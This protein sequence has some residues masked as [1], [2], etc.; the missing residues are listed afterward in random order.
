[1]TVRLSHFS[2]VLKVGTLGLLAMLLFL[3]GR[4]TNQASAVAYV[5]LFGIMLLQV[6]EVLY[7]VPSEE[8]E[9]RWWRLVALRVSILL[10]LGLAS[11]LVAVTGGSGSIYELV[12]LLPIVSA[13]M[14]LPGREV[15]V[16]VGG[17]VV[18]MVGFIVTGE[19]LTAS[20][21]RVKEFQDAVAATVYFTIA[22]ILAYLFA[23]AER[24]QRVHYQSL[25][26][27]LADTN[28][29][30][31]R[32]QTELTDRLHQ[33]AQMEERIQQ[34][35]QMAV[36]GEVAA[37][38]A[39]EVRNP[40]G[41]IKGATEMLAARTSEPA[42]QR[43]VAVL[44]E[45]VDRLNRAVESILRL[46]TPLRIQPSRVHLQDLL[47][48]VTQAATGWSSPDRHAVK[49]SVPAEPVWLTGDRDL[50]HQALTNLI[51]NAVQAMPGGGIVT[52]AMPQPA[53]GMVSVTIGDTGVGLSAEELK[54]LGEPF[55]TKRAGGVGLGFGLARRII[56]E[57]GG[58]LAVNSQ[59]GHGT[60]VTIQ[61]PAETQSNIGRPPVEAAGSR[62]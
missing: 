40:L 61:L 18:A 12:Y 53:D 54:R 51:R 45:E 38:V 25:A 62:R 47:R 13:A 16:A 56:L 19:Q 49:L 58:T 43:H 5:S 42:T 3:L 17:A 26:A 21:G 46:A 24:D 59:V 39:H 29:E 22:G 35:S 30:L 57:H 4:I 52:I 15:A 28:T 2:V 37:Q 55:F 31:R 34:I 23:K 48:A 41:I 27:A 50:L 7:A 36:L 60:S 11:V 1:M 9:W 6:L 33:L 8:G 10:Q 44:L 32:V 20:I 14:K